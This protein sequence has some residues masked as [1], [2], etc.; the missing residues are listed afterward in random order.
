VVAYGDEET[1]ELKTE[2]ALGLGLGGVMVW[3]VPHD[4]S[5]QRFSNSFLWRVANRNGLT[6]TIETESTRYVEIHK[7][8]N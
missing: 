4:T 7:K 5:D 8:I 1:L 2:F 3:A 6:S